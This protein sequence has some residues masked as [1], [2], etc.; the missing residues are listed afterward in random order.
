MERLESIQSMGYFV[1]EHW[2]CAVN[3]QLS[4]NK[5]MS[6]FF[7]DCQTRGHID[8]RDAYFGGLIN[9]FSYNNNLIVSY[10]IILYCYII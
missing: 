3:K 10:V 5:E 7:N 8:P 2:E 6:N 9:K 4:N 1:E